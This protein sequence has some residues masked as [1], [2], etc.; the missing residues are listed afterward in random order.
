MNASLKAPFPYFGGKRRIASLVWSALGDVPNYVETHC[1]SAAV[2]LG[3]P[4]EPR[5]ETINDLDCHV[6]NFWRAMSADPEAVAAAA[7]WPV[8]EADLHARSTTLGNDADFVGRVHSDPV[9]YDPKVAGVWAWGMCTAIGG[10][11]LRTDS[12]AMPRVCG[13]VAGNG[14][15]A[16]AAIPAVGH[17]GR[18][19]H[20]PERE[21]LVHWFRRL[22]AR[23]RRVRVCCGDFTRVLA[24]SVTGASNTT[25]SMGMSPCGAFLDPP[26]QPKGRAKVYANE[27]E[28]EFERAWVWSL[29]NG[30]DP[31]FRIVLCGYDD[32][33]E[34]PEGWRAIDWKAQGGHGNRNPDNV[35]RFRERIWI[36]PHCLDLGGDK[37]LGLFGGASDD[38]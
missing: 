34:T 30:N 2:L 24:G 28:D 5:I 26:Y 36:S 15:H 32:G 29:E 16:G 37:Q 21:E 17:S 23:L 8:N 19:I 38:A 10:N 35:N 25:K 7:D 31:H 1:G 6:A 22:Q 33:R 20:S 3:R 18:G 27:G 9:F 13:W 14:L 12:S 4:T 11:W